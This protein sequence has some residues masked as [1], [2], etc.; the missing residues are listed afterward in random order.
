MYVGMKLLAIL[1][2]KQNEIEVTK[3]ILLYLNIYMKTKTSAY[4]YGGHEW[5]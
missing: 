2:V 4:A 1:S 5:L 3:Y